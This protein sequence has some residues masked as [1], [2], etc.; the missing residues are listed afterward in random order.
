MDKKI[1]YEAVV[2]KIKHEFY[3]DKCN[4]FLGESTEYDD[5]YYPEHGRRE[6]SVNI[7]GWLKFR[8]HLCDECNEFFVNKIRTLLINNFN[9]KEDKY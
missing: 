3:C 2:K 4:K 6:Y 8:G 1:S 5:G 7:N 9:F